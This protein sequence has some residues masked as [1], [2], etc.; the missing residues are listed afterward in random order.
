MG[1]YAVR[2]IF[3]LE[4]FPNCFEERITLWEAGSADEAIDRA[5]AEAAEYAPG[6][7]YLGLAQA[8]AMFE[9]PTD[10]AEVFSLMRTSILDGA[11]YIERYFATGDE[12]QRDA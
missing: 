3:R 7:G 9:P 8:F 2:C 4:E 6:G 11:T 1:W 5:E 10:G 12:H